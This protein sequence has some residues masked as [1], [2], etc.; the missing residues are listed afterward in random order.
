MAKTYNLRRLE[1]LVLS[2]F[3]L[4]GLAALVY[5]VLWA[6]QLELVLG[7]TLHAVS[8]IL[9]VFM[10]GLALGSLIFGRLVDRG[11]INPLLLYGL[12]ELGIGIYALFTPWI[13]KGVPLL[14]LYLPGLAE[15]GISTFSAVFFVSLLVLIIPTT[16]M[17]GT[18]PALTKYMVSRYEEMGNKV[19]KL[20]FLNTLGAGAGAFLAGFLLIAYL[21]I[22]PTTYVAAIINLGIAVG[23]LLLLQAPSQPKAISET[24]T[25]EAAPQNEPEEAG[26]KPALR[27]AGIVLLIGYGLAGF[28][29][30]GLEV[31]WTRVLVM[32]LGSSVY[33]FALMLTA[34]LVGIALGSS[35]MVKLV[36]KV[37]N[38]WLCFALI[39]VLIGVAVIVLNPI[40]GQTPLVFLRV[41]LSLEESFW[42][43][44][45][46]QLVLTFLLMLI[47]TF[48]MGAAFPVVT[49]LYA[50]DLQHIGQKI[51][52]VYAA[53][54]MGSIVGPLAVSFV[55]I[56]WIGIQTSILLVA[57]IYIG[58]GGIILVITPLKRLA[59]KG[60]VLVA[61]CLIVALS[62][63]VPAWNKQ[64][65]TSGI[66]YHSRTWADAIAAGNIAEAMSERKLLFYKEGQLATVTVLKGSAEK[67][68]ILTING[69][70]D[71]SNT[72]DLTTQLLVGHLPMLMHPEPQKV[73]V[74]GLGSGITTGAVLQHPLVQ[75]VDVVEIEPV[76]AEAA[77]YFAE[78]NHNALKDPKLR[79]IEGDARNFV[80][81]SKEKYDVIVAEPSNPFV[82]G[83]T[84]LFSR[85]MFELYRKSL[86]DDGIAV[87]WMHLYYMGTDDLK[88]MINTFRQ[89]FPYT[90]LWGRYTDSDI[91]LLGTRQPLSI[92]FATFQEKL[93]D[94]NVRLDLARTGDDDPYRLL[95]Y[96][97]M[98]EKALASYTAGAAINRDSYPRLEFSAPKYINQPTVGTNI[99][100][101]Q[102]FRT[103]AAASLNQSTPAAVTERVQSG[104]RSREKLLE[105]MVLQDQGQEE[106]ATVLWEELLKLEQGDSLV[107]DIL[108]SAYES[109]GL[110]TF[111]EG[112]FV[113]SRGF[114]QRILEL[115]PDNTTAHMS[116]GV[117]AQSEGKFDEAIDRFV[118]TTKL[119]PQNGLAF[120][121]MGYAYISKREYIQALP[122]LTTAIELMPEYAFAYANRGF[123]YLSLGRYDE[124]IA[125]YN[126][127]IRYSRGY[128]R[129][130]LDRGKAYQGKNNYAAA[131][132]DF[133]QAIKLEPKAAETYAYRGRLYLERQEYQ[134]AIKDFTRAIEMEPSPTTYD[135]R[136]LARMKLGQNTFALEDLDK[137]IELEENY[138][139]PYYRRGYV[140]EALGR[141]TDA[142]ES[143]EK[144]LTL[145]Q[146]TNLIGQAKQ[147]LSRLRG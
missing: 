144:F 95:S 107:Q 48:L 44:Q 39:E 4:S 24:V 72:G 87:Q 10:A 51:A 70:P 45:G 55:L 106:A 130:Y 86:K 34:F 133:T 40:L 134:K 115:K 41:V 35:L 20:Y 25:E 98:E 57:W 9:S 132:K 114:F 21:G 3:F 109:L 91:L 50:R 17:G 78:A 29:A 33:A 123:S 69:K 47:P 142:I 97:L 141:K 30:L 32:V 105:G 63:L 19:A 85:E 127:A 23:V 37:K 71:A 96:L 138:D 43:L 22:P 84:N 77:A 14:G 81:A 82:S 2:W 111:K 53:N 6:R 94:N 31:L 74:V 5:Q 60:A 64:I 13:L 1:P 120:Y 108:V 15:V 38:L 118:T 83:S 112:E 80:Q 36:D 75:R 92:D 100:S 11:K 79:L 139:L 26:A 49:K 140:L 66:Y 129:A 145:S 110:A 27:S 12:L 124:A 46:V 59:I 121:D 102:G 76:V 147:A 28:A 18:L 93:K 56:P 113:K 117:I 67:D 65:I 136:A 125:D 137:A 146:D 89:V 143:Y 58:V 8:A 101:M 62:F 119:A 131:L 126:Q 61:L 73:L 7:S 116:L 52:A 103:S 54:T 68:R 42:A 135:N 90:T 16:L 99:A 128:G 88:T 122:P 104:F